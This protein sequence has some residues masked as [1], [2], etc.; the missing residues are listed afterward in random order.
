MGFQLKV[1]PAR[2]VFW[3]LLRSTIFWWC[4]FNLEDESLADG[5]KS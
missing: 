4:S 2:F 1:M 3:G 5:L